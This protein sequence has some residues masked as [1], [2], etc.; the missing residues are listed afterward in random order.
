MV[1]IE[2]ENELGRLFFTGGGDALLKTVQVAGLGPPDREFQ[3]TGYSGQAGQHL[4]SQKDMARIITISGDL[5]APGR[6]QQEL[7]A[8][9]RILYHPGRLLIS[10]GN[11]RRC[12]SCRLTSFDEPERHGRGMAS[13]VLQFT[14]DNPYFTDER[15]QSVQLFYR[16]DLVSGRFT[17]PCVFTE[18]VTR[19]NVVNRGD[20]KAEPVITLYNSY[21][22]DA[23]VFSL[24]SGIHMMNHSTGQ[25]LVFLHTT[26]PG[27]IV[28]I[29]IPK[30]Q[31][32]SSR[33]GDITGTL[34]EDSFLSD[35]WLETG[36][37]DVEVINYTDD[38][39][40]VLLTYNNQY[41]E[42]VL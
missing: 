28:T 13:F 26:V 32:I 20:V 18:C 33:S 23:A 21:S 35:F 27:E 24:R 4:I 10:S 3:V 9:M 31:I 42:A 22:E 12:I 30:R 39:I 36:V 41:I 40:R 15:E 34:A 29:D 38:D 5:A 19:R 2:F 17:L 1:H 7:S 16:R 6:L 37:N 14:C 25:A 11:R 8:M